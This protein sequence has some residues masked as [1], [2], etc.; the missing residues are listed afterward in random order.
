MRIHAICLALNEE[1]YIE[2]QL[3][4]LYPFCSGISIL[5][6]YDRDWYGRPVR[7]DRTADK[8]LN[9]PDPE[10][11]IH[12]VLRRWRDEA[13]ARNHEMLSLLARPARRVQSHGSPPG[14]I[15]AFHTPPDYFLIVDADEIYDVAT[16]PAILAYLEQRRPRGM[17]VL[18]YNYART[19][20]QR[21]PPEVE[22]FCHFG[23]LRPGVLFS[24]LRVV[25]WNE[26]RLAKAL[27]WL[28]LP[29]VSARLFGFIECPP[30]VGVFHHGWCLGDDERLRL[31]RMRSSHRSDTWDPAY[32]AGVDALR[33]DFVPTSEL[34]RN[35][36]EAIWPDGYFDQLPVAHS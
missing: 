30:E 15:R 24:Y 2:T 22:R 33:T 35:I 9:F 16:L 28:R 18:G 20:N 8:L 34:P 31:K 5:S 32:A 10:G 21:V 1:L 36:R 27:R 4:T 29:D 26:S 7:P 12:F 23:F 3:R 6:Q 13:A 11:K 17:R 14:E 25:S 19:W